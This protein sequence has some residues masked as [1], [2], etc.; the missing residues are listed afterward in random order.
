MLH[1]PSMEGLGPI[2]REAHY[3]ASEYV[4]CPYGNYAECTTAHEIRLKY[5]DARD[6]CLALSETPAECLPSFDTSQ[7]GHGH[8]D[9]PTCNLGHGQRVS[10]A[11]QANEHR[12]NTQTIEHPRKRTRHSQVNVGEQSGKR[13]H[14]GKQA[15]NNGVFPAVGDKAHEI[16]NGA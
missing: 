12:T 9:K 6:R 15:S 4:R 3:D 10:D 11:A 2:F 1:V 5:A 8:D 13:P 14:N 7:C 16:S